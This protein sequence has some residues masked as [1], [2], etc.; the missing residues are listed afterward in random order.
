[1]NVLSPH[2]SER[3][4]CLGVNYFVLDIVFLEL[5]TLFFSH[6]L[7]LSFGV[8]NFLIIFSVH[9][10]LEIPVFVGPLSFKRIVLV[11]KCIKKQ[12]VCLKHSQIDINLIDCLFLVLG[13]Q[14]MLPSVVICD[15]LWC[16]FVIVLLQRV[17]VLACQGIP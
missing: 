14:H 3:L 13:N 15:G 12:W 9:L 7:R 5:F 10:D 17:N 4:S 8:L 11:D 16:R 6:F 2:L 1:V